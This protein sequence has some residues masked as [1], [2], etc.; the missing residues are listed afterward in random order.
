MVRILLNMPFLSILGPIVRFLANQIVRKWY[1]IV[2]FRLIFLSVFSPIMLNPLGT[3]VGIPEEFQPLIT[4]VDTMSSS[5]PATVL[6]CLLDEGVLSPC[7][8]EQEDGSRWFDSMYI[9]R[10]LGSG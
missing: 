3:R 7:S 9:R 2:G 8:A 5:S 6:K 1:G 10:I 4:F